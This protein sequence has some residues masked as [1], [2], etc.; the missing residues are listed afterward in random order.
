MS[1]TTKSANTLG[2]IEYLDLEHSPRI[3]VLALGADLDE[4]TEMAF[5]DSL[6][7]QSSGRWVTGRPDPE[8]FVPGDAPILRS[9]AMNGL[10]RDL[11]LGGRSLNSTEHSMIYVNHMACIAALSK[12]VPYFIEANL[13]VGLLSSSPPPTDVLSGLRLPYP[14][15]SVYFG[16]ELELPGDLRWPGHFVEQPD[17][18]VEYAISHGQG[19]LTGAVLMAGPGGVGLDNTMFWLVS[20]DPLDHPDFPEVAFDRRRSIMLADRRLSSWPHL[21][22]NVAASVAWLDWQV[23]DPL[24]LP[25]PGTKAYRKAVRTSQFRK[26]EPRGAVGGVHVIDRSMSAH[27]TQRSEP[28]GR[29]VREHTRTGHWRAVRV[30]T[31]DSE[32]TITG[33]VQGEPGVDWHYEGRWIA[34]TVVNPG[35][36]RDERQVVYRVPGPGPS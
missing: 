20:T 15:V 21:A 4:A 22:E 32:G 31:R 28:T 13:V 25:E 26:R 10:L 36:T 30:A 12:A 33:N 17:H 16:V 9:Q 19:R 27:S 3:E 18:S 8:Q 1:D 34:P 11:I 7:L 29:S 5:R 35:A 14:V 6:L 2:V 24:E 23:P